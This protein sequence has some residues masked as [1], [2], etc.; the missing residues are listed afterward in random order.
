MGDPALA[1]QV[2]GV[3]KTF[4]TVR[5]EAID[6]LSAVTFDVAAGE[7]VSIVGPSG[8]GKSTLLRILA[9]LTEPT[10]GTLLMHGQPARGP[11]DDI[12]MVFQESVLLPWRSVF[13]NA[14]LPLEIKHR[15]DAAGR[16]RVR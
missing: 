15:A 10:S 14:M 3:S 11:R 13:Q 4:Q 1:I 16:A 8:C 2:R 5:G 7:F 6:A 12:G 9:G